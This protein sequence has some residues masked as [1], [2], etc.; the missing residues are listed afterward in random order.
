MESRFAKLLETQFK[1][2]KKMEEMQK[3]QYDDRA[4]LME[5]NKRL[6][7][8]I[9][10][11]ASTIVLLNSHLDKTVQRLQQLEERF[12]S[13][14]GNRSSTSQADHDTLI[15]EMT[16][17]HSNLRVMFAKMAETEE[18]LDGAQVREA[19]HD[20]RILGFMSDLSSRILITE[21]YAF[22]MNEVMHSLQALNAG[23]GFPEL[24]AIAHDH[25]GFIVPAERPPNWT[26]QDR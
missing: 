21:N 24:P 4:K 22:N 8:Q 9:R 16:T 18:E 19:H 13:V 5:T 17:V 1:L 10:Q 14:V 12:N 23:P 20:Q 7:G 26:V 11:H 25:W 6:A 3:V 15:D 2:S